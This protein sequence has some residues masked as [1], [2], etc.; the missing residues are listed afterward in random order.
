[1][2]NSVLAHIESIVPQVVANIEVCLSSNKVG[3]VNAALTEAK[4]KTAA[5]LASV[6]DHPNK[7]SLSS[8]RKALTAID[9]LLT[10]LQHGLET[11]ELKVKDF[12]AVCSNLK[13]NF[14]PKLETSISNEQEGFKVAS[15]V[16]D[17]KGVELTAEQ[18]AIRQALLTHQVSESGITGRY[19]NE[20]DKP[21][22]YDK[23]Q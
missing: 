18:Q 5:A 8:T 21:F 19:E 22:D 1:M 7:R 9:N 17:E 14:I 20:Q 4:A 11:R 10:G 3:T 2:K 12:R 13:T 15:G 16:T 6:I 23:E